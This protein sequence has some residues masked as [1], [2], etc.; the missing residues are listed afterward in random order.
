[1]TFKF[2]DVEL[3]PLEVEPV[4]KDGV[5][6]YKLPKTDKYYPS[7]TSITSFKNAK[8]FKEWRTKIGE[9]EANR[10]TARATQRGTAFHS[11]AE[12]YINGELDLDK[13]LD[14]NPLSVRMF[15][16]A[17]DTL[18]RINNIHCLESFLYSHYLG[19]AGRVDCIAEFD[20]ELAVIDFKTS[21]KEK[22]EEH[23][24]NYFVQETAYAAMFLERTGIE[25]KKI[26]TLIA[27]EEGSIQI[28]QKHNLDDYLQLLKSYIEEFVRGKVN[29]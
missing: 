26:V 22:K 24:E 27:T 25:V 23:I 28:F 13:Y 3:E 15:Q 2:V 8:F 14:N 7:V 9:D 17:K 29:A 18:N 6:F 5:R 1:M 19:L 4:N 20:G 12:D 10:I 16:S 21:T 11:I